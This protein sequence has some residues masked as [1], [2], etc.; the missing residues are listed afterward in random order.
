MFDKFRHFVAEIAGR[1]RFYGTGFSPQKNR[2]IRFLIAGVINTL[3]GFAIYSV[4]IIIGVAVWL[5]LLAGML[6]GTAFNFFTTGGY[7]FRD[8][9]LTRFPRFVICYLFV[10]GVN[11]LLIEII[12]FWLN[13]KILPQAIVI[14]PLALLSYFLM[15]RF[16]FSTAKDSIGG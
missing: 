12:S 15:A 10:Y 5:S 16:V 4:F 1:N 6:S 8:L 9:S 3:F 14:F 7:V 11:I 13:S 2:A